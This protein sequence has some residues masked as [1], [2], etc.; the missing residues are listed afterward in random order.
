MSFLAT[1]SLPLPASPGAVVWLTGLSGAGKSTL[2]RHLQRQLQAAGQSSFLLDGDQLRQG[3]CCDLD[4]SIPGRRENLR[5]A[6]A[7]CQLLADAGL[8]VLAAFVSPARADRAMVRA[9]IQGA[10]FVEVYCSASLAACEQRDV[11]GLYARARRGDIRDF[12]GISA[13]YEPPLAADLVIQSDSC[14][15]DE[16]VQQLMALLVRRGLIDT[17]RNSA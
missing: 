17:E 9:M 16:G 14:S 5:R 7:L 12:T 11:K 6:A 2:S 15:V 4:Y 13:P 3:L 8:I 1:N 10:D